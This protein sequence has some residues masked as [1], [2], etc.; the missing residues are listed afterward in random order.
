MRAQPWAPRSSQQL[1]VGELR[2]GFWGR[3]HS[4][5]SSA[6]PVQNPR[7][8]WKTGTSGIEL[9]WAFV[10]TDIGYF[11]GV[12]QSP[13]YGNLRPS[14]VSLHLSHL[15]SSSYVPKSLP[16]PENTSKV[17]NS[18]PKSTPDPPSAEP[19]CRAGQKDSLEV[20][21]PVQLGQTCSWLGPQSSWC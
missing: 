4:A 17:W 8:P 5:L 21:D 1:R 2:K 11:E 3:C 10:G 19:T 12:T 14:D 20:S 9:S 6:F 15:P 7:L 13:S 18:S 16:K